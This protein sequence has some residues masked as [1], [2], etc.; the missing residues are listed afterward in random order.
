MKRLLLSVPLA[1]PP[2]ATAQS[3]P[4]PP[5]NEGAAAATAGTVAALRAPAGEEKKEDC[6]CEADVPADAFAVVNGVRVTRKEID[7]PLAAAIGDL[8]RQVIEAR[9]N[10]LDLQINSRLLDAEARRR[11]T[12]ALTLIKDEVMAKA[13][14]PTEA[15]PRAFYE[16]NRARIRAEFSVVQADIVNYLLGERQRAAAKAL[17]ERLRAAAQVKVL[18]AAATPPASAAERV[19]VFATVN[20]Q[21]V[22]SSYVEDALRPLIFSVQEQVYALRR[23]AAELRVNDLLLEAEAKKRGVTSKALLDAEVARRS[24][25]VTEKEAEEFYN[26]N[27]ERISGD[28]AQ[29]KEQVLEYL[30]EQGERKPTRPSPPSCAARPKSGC[31]S[32][33]HSRLLTRSRPTTSR[34]E[35]IS[36]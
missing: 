12:S 5:P 17:A 15:G 10:E 2:A 25:P 23:R 27:K 24:K 31:C 14:Q 19:R 29:V 16:Q 6:G 20:G 4:A 28:F 3:Q 7:D 9:K 36:Q 22:R 11:G 30:K 34:P 26:Q 33:P 21:P 13:A 18:V 8:Q 32:R 1:V 35:A